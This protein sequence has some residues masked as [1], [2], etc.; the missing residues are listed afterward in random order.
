MQDTSINNKQSMSDSQGIVLSIITASYN[1]YNRLAA[2]VRSVENFYGDSRFEHIVIDGNSTDQTKKYLQEISCH[3]NFI[4]LSEPDSGIYDA[5]NKGVAIANGAYLLF[6]NCGDQ[7]TTSP[8]YVASCLRLVIA[9]GVA[10]IL[11][12]DC[13]VQDQ[14]YSF[15]LRPRLAWPYRM[16]TSHQA[17]LFASPFLRLHRYDTNYRIAADFNLYL[18]AER[19]RVVVFTGVQPLTTIEA[20][21]IASENPV[22]SYK[23]Y[24]RAVAEN[25]T[26]WVKWAAILRIGSKAAMVIL[27]KKGLPRRLL[28][29]LQRKLG[30]LYYG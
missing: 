4:C 18:K 15:V 14:S 16:P 19:T 28:G 5:M 26:G 25:L 12:F 23:E 10:D 3:D 22:L 11:C 21:G 6:L 9:E 8:D 17:M 24:L 1:D 7:I 2:T 13:R 27:F 30:T 29:K 20:V